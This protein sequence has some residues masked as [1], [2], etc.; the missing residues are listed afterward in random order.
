L[1][2]ASDRGAAIIRQFFV[3]L[4]FDGL[5]P[6]VMPGLVPLA[7]GGLMWWHI[8]ELSEALAANGQILGLNLVELAP[9]NDLK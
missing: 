3:P 4:D 2:G 8:I 5:D 7:P 6:S 1:H 9:K